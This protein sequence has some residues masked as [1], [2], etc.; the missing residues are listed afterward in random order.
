MKHLF[1]LLAFFLPSLSFGLTLTQTAEIVEITPVSTG[2]Y[3]MYWS[4]DPLSA[5][6][7]NVQMNGT[8][9]QQAIFD[10]VVQTKLTIGV[11]Y[12]FMESSVNSPA[13]SSYASCVSDPDTIAVYPSFLMTDGVTMSPTVAGTSLAIGTISG[14]FVSTFF[15]YI[16]ALMT[17]STFIGLIVALLTLFFGIR[18]IS[19]KIGSEF[20]FDY[21]FRDADEK[22]DYLIA[23]ER[24]A[25]IKKDYKL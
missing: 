11:T 10:D 24:D 19:R 25:Q 16:V 7:F 2:N 21:R 17:N 4:A 13:C 12:W 14:V 9:I 3:L 22:L 6:D 15:D 18:L 1:L 8:G 23:M 5:W 20:S